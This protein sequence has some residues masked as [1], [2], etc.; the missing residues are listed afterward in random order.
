LAN[1]IGWDFYDLDHVIEIKA[2]KKVKDIFK[3][4]GEAYFRKLET[5]TL[6]ELSQRN[7]SIIA[8]GGGTIAGKQI[9]K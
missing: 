4:P 3:D 5:E 8:L 7:D 6:L 9:W 2:G 1:T